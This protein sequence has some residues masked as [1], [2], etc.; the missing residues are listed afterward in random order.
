MKKQYTKKQIVE[1]IKHW[2]SVLKRMDESKSP[3]LDACSKEFGEDVVFDSNK[4]LFVLNESNISK[5]FSILDSFIFASK[6]KTLDNLKIFVGNPSTL[7][8]TI[9]EYSNGNPID[10]SKYF[11]LY[12]PDQYNFILPNGEKRFNIKKNGIFIN[13]ETNKCSTFAYAASNIC[14]EMIHV[15]DMYFGK[16]YNYVIWA[17][18]NGAPVEVIDYNSHKTS[19]FK[20]KKGEFETMTNI[21]IED[22]GNDY[23]FEKF[24]EI[25]SKDI[26]LLKE[27]DDLSKC[28]PYVFPKKIKDKYKDS[29]VVHF[30]NDGYFSFSFGIPMPK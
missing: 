9:L 21:P 18:N 16:L 22:A 24:N 14:H 7:N 12:K 15:Y 23:S 13:T 27:T 19:V 25:A 28:V 1:A 17:I 10:L 30:D 8:S 6:L 2:E 11:A 26:A 4:M 20:Q 3:L 29:N 5:L